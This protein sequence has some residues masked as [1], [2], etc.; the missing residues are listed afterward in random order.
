[1]LHLRSSLNFASML[2]EKEQ[3][4]NAKTRVGVVGTS[5]YARLMHL[6]NL[7]SHPDAII[8]AICGQNA[9]RTAE[10]AAQYG[11]QPF[12]DYRAML[13]AG[14]LDGVIVAAPDDLHYA[15]TMAVLD[16]GLHVI[17]EKPLAMNVTQAREMRDR[18]VAAGICHMVPFTFAWRPVFMH[19]AALVA[20]GYLGTL[21][22]AQINYLGGYG[23][24]GQYRWRFDPA[25]ANGALGDLGPHMIH[26]AR[27]LAGEIIS[28]DAQLGTYGTRPGAQANDSALLSVGF[29]G[30]AQGIIHV[31]A[32]AH[33]AERGM[34]QRIAL[35]GS[36][37]TLE[38]TTT[39]AEERIVGA[40]AG[41]AAF[42]EIAVPDALWGDTDRTDFLDMFRKHAAGARLWI[43]AIR[44]GSA[45][46]PDFE[47]GYQAQLV[48]DAAIRSQHERR[49]VAIESNKR[50]A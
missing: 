23:R 44:S 16:A 36:D 24:D 42:A 48:I 12:T 41:D 35:H 47:D 22:H 2:P 21:Y 20:A 34:E 19:A 46:K 1:M 11:A 33:V 13:A 30:G 29:A 7:K 26:V 45:V 15:M 49:R 28:V 40:R 32:A 18:A 4:M 27:M 10:V 43:D 3:P 25:R 50:S 6:E 37:G 31:S 5:E 8:S 14:G 17:C 9:E 39:F 38:I